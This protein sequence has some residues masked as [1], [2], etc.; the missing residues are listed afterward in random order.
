MFFGH[1]TLPLGTVDL[2]FNGLLKPNRIEGGA[3]LELDSLFGEEHDKA[4]WYLAKA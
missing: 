3:E 4:H 2:K 1:T